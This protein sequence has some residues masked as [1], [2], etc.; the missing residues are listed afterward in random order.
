M[1][2]KI[3]IIR[4]G[5]KEIWQRIVPL[6]QAGRDFDLLFWQKAGSQARFSA[7]WRML[8]EYEMLRGRKNGNKFRLRR[9]FQNI[10]QA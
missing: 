3:K 9:S 7:A 1:K 6:Y 10:Q 2:G 5:G 8:G 4:K